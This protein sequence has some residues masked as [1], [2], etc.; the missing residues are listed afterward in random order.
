MKS[1]EINVQAKLNYVFFGLAITNVLFV[2]ISFFFAK[3]NPSI[4]PNSYGDYERTDLFYVLAQGNFENPYEFHPELPSLTVQPYLPLPFLINELFGI[5]VDAFSKEMF[6]VQAW[7]YTSII[8]INFI[9]WKI[10]KGYK[11]IFKLSVITAFGIFSVPILYIFRTGNLQGYSTLII[12]LAFISSKNRVI[13]FLSTILTASFKPQYVV[14]NLAN[15]L[16]SFK[17]LRIY[18]AA[19]FMGG[20]LTIYGFYIFGDNI[21]NNIKYFSRSLK[22]FTSATPEFIVHLNASIIGNLS[23]IE[24]YFFPESLQNLYTLK[25]KNY[26]LVIVLFFILYV[27]Y[28]LV[29]VK[30]FSWA[31]VLV[32]AGIPIFLTPVSFS[33]SLTLLLIPLVLFLRDF[34]N[35]DTFTTLVIQ[36]KFNYIFFSIALF[37]LFT[38]KPVQVILV[39]N[40]ADTNL[41]TMLDSF[42]FIMLLTVIVRSLNL[43]NKLMK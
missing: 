40:V 28:R 42:G 41:Y 19:L 8:L 2:V 10:L 39:K 24:A 25:F 15:Y 32:L 16:K 35:R 33:Y 1:R 17:E 31:L 13:P 18:I 43:K 9:I 36:D 23:S 30:N 14:I 26:I 7:T 5:K 27:F 34:R 22:Q 37:L 20:V 21:L 6:Y 12:L 38:P 11:N 3:T 4:L 29:V